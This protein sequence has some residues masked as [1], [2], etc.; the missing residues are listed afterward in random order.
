MTIV[1]WFKRDLRIRDNPALAYAAAQSA[2][3]NHPIIPLYIVEPDYWALPDTS[4]R[5]WDFIKEC[6]EE[7]RADLTAIGTPL[8]VRS[9]NAIDIFQDLHDTYGIRHIVSHEEIGNAWTY[10][11]DKA[12]QTW[13][14]NHQI[15]WKEGAHTPVIRG[16]HTTDWETA[17]HVFLSTKTLLPPPSLQAVDITPGPIPT[18]TDLNLYDHCPGRQKGGRRAAVDAYT[19]FLQT[20]GKTYRQSL[21]SPDRAQHAGARISPH[22]AYG[23]LSMREV[24]RGLRGRLAQHPSKDWVSALNA[25]EQRT[26]GRD[27]FMQQ[28]ES[29]CWVEHTSIH[30]DMETLRPRPGNHSHLEAWSSGTTGYPF[31]D[32]CMRYLNHYGWINFRMRAML[33]SFASYQLWLDWRETGALLAQ[34]FTDYEPG[35]HWPMIQMQSG[36]NPHAVPRI[37]NPIKQGHDQDPKGIFTKTWCPELKNVPLAH[38]QEPYTWANASTLEGHYPNP[39]VD[40]KQSTAFARDTTFAFHKTTTKPPTQDTQLSLL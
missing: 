31:V 23:T 39:I 6:L 3:T 11:R 35:I 14:Q 8:V 40:L 37:Y 34:K 10:Q 9:G 17:R 1:V 30:P 18:S 21:S 7:L 36:T 16:Q 24:Y 22:L 13:C 32:A 12:L 33:I 20:R 28:F 29:N 38:L 26:A 15:P 19:T 27:Y 4:G 2:R 5:H 25:F